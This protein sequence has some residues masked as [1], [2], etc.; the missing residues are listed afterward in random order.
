MAI[1]AAVTFTAL[2]TDY[3]WDPRITVFMQAASPQG[4][5]WANVSDFVYAAST[6]GELAPIVA[7][8]PDIVG[9]ERVTQT[10]RVRQAWVA[11]RA[12]VAKASVVKVSGLDDGD[13]ETLLDQ[14]TLEGF[15]DAFYARYRISFPPAIEPGDLA[16]SRLGIRRR[17][18]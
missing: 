11:L 4:L 15:Q 14:P 12:I 2:E 5:G 18:L 13:L 7:L 8:V 1:P 17:H 6:E 9:I 3:H 16:V 10:S